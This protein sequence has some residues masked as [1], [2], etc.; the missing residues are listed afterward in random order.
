[1]IDGSW[2]LIDNLT[3]NMAA[4]L[5]D[6]PVLSKGAIAFTLAA[7][8]Y[9]VVAARAWSV[10]ICSDRALRRLLHV[11]A[12][13]GGGCLFLTGLFYDSLLRGLDGAITCMP[14]IYTYY[15]ASIMLSCAAMVF[16]GAQIFCALHVRPA[17]LLR[18]I[19]PGLLGGWLFAL[20]VPVYQ[21]A[22]ILRGVQ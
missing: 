4:Y 2:H 22:V 16:A 3:A 18:G 13:A 9:A 19:I 12:M 7:G 1:M 8:C 17:P 14:L 21:F 11:C 6:H 5:S 15:P 10:S 20:C